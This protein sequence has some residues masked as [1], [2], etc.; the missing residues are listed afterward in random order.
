MIILDAED[1]RRSKQDLPAAGLTL[2]FP[3]KAV[4]RSDSPLPDYETSEARQKFL[5][6]T[7]SHRKILDA[8]LWRA[9]LYAFVIYVLLSAVI[10]V[11]IVLLVRYFWQFNTAS[12]LHCLNYRTSPNT[13]M[14]IVMVVNPR[15]LHGIRVHLLEHQIRAFGRSVIRRGAIGRSREKTPNMISSLAGTSY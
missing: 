7:V 4:A 13:P 10:G 1:Q 2:R 3:E 6:Q 11:P 12:L 9:V 15:A 5:L 8:K 14:H